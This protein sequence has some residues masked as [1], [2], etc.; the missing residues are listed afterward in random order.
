MLQ[1]LGCELD[2]FVFLVDKVWFAQSRSLFV[3][4]PLELV[5]LAMRIVLELLVVLVVLLFVSALLLVGIAVIVVVLSLMFVMV[6]LQFAEQRLA[7]L[8]LEASLGALA[9]QH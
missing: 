3:V 9:L 4:V 6:V 2:G 7:L 8:G 5:M 1:R